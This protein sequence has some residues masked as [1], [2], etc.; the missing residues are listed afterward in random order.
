MDLLEKTIKQNI[1]Y[2]LVIAD[3]IY[4]IIDRMEDINND[5]SL[6]DEINDYI[7]YYDDQWDIMRHYFYSEIEKANFNDAMDMFYNDCYK[8]LCAYREA[9]GQ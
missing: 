4:S 9:L 1:D 2:S 7:I 5:D 6:I 8:C 3:L